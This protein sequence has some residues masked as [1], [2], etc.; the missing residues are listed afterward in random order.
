[1]SQRLRYLKTIRVIAAVYRGL[2]P[3]KRTLTHRH[4]AGLTGYSQPFDLA[5]G[6]VFVKQ[7]ETL[8]Y[9]DL[10]SHASTR[11]QAPLIANV[12]G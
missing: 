6:Y 2:G 11:E 12:R 7:S 9:C 4:W 1:V 8:C 3:L 10:L 5:A